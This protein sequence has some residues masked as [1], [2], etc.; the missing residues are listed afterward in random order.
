MTFEVTQSDVPPSEI[1]KD[2]LVARNA[3]KFAQI[4]EGTD[5][6]IFT[7]EE[8][9][10]PTNTITI[11]DGLEPTRSATQG[12]EEEDGEQWTP[13]TRVRGTSYL[14][15]YRKAKEISN[16]LNKFGRI[17]TETYT[18]PNI[19]RNGAPFPLPKNQRNQFIFV[20]NWKVWRMQKRRA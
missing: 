11:Y 18:Y 1:L 9:A 7:A 12:A 13:Q 4:A 20:Q 10:E 2:I 8:P 15:T 6:G 16:I 5:W 3:G 19:V 14:E 17:E